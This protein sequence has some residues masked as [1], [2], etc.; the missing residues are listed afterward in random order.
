MNAVTN[1]F[2]HK[3]FACLCKLMSE[4]FFF[5]LT[6]VIYLIIKFKGTKPS[7]FSKKHFVQTLKTKVDYDKARKFRHTLLKYKLPAFYKHNFEISDLVIL[8]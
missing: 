3:S 6:L 2:T 7:N 8:H 4:I 1:M 5:N